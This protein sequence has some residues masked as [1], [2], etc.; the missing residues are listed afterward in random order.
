MSTSKPS[1][2]TTRAPYQPV[3]QPHEIVSALIEILQRVQQH[4]DPIAEALVRSIIT[5]A[6]KGN[7]DWSTI[8]G[9]NGTQR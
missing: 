8:G 5:T 3:S 1:S 4:N 9:Q 7:V 2:G 6:F